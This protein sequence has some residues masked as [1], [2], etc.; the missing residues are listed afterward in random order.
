[1]LYEVI[2]P[3]GKFDYYVNLA[4]EKEDGY[5]DDSGA[6]ISRVYGRIGYHPTGDTDVTVSYTLVND[7]LKQAGALPLS[8]AAVNPRANFTPGDYT[9]NNSNVV[10]LTGRQGLPLGFSLNVN[11]FYRQLDQEQFGIGQPVFP[12]SI[13]S[14]AQTNSTTQSWGGTVQLAQKAP[15]FGRQNNLSYNFV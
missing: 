15:I 14:M 10:R 11:G 8:I 5:R 6:N 3:F 12:G 1:M 2:T 7:K 9:D 13:L 4:R